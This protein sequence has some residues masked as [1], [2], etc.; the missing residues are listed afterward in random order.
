MK[1]VYL[2]SP[3]SHTDKTIVSR[4]VRQVTHAASELLKTGLNVFSPI[5][6][7]H[8]IAEDHSTPGDWKFWAEIDEDYIKRCD[9]V[10]I[11]QLD[12]YCQSVGIAAEIKIA[13]KYGKPISFVSYPQM[14][15]VTSWT[16]EP[17]ELNLVKPASSV[18]VIGLTGYARSGKDTLGEYIST[19]FG[20]KRIGFADAV[21][22]AL[23][24]LNP[25]IGFDSLGE[26]RVEDI[27][28][29]TSWEAAKGTREIRELL[30]RMGTEAG[31]EIHGGRCWIDIAKRKALA[32]TKVV[33]TDVRFDNEA[34]MIRNEL[35]GTVIR[36]ERPGIEPA[37]SHAS[38]KK[39]SENLI[40]LTIINDGSI[41]DLC[42]KFH[43]LT[44]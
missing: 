19:A 32:E 39:I 44:N 29:D 21:K 23:Y 6:H 1:L 16:P 12:G 4:R 22:D 42:E 26:D 31:R 27:V 34:E 7:S 35:G 41:N 25:I 15:I 20:F 3:Y 28:E 9:E 2:A 13:K 40:D 14:E 24:A 10:Y 8:P 38:E 33:F 11:L 18:E 30:Q 43:N 17:L 5:V 36:I 37:N